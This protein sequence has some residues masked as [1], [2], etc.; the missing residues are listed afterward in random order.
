MNRQD[1]HTPALIPVD[2]WERTPTGLRSTDGQHTVDGVVV[3]SDPVGERFLIA[4]AEG[5]DP[6]G[7]RIVP[8]ELAA[9]LAVALRTARAEVESKAFDRLASDLLD[10]AR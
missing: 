8:S 2:G 9:Q 4:P 1:E 3:G 6:V 10:T 7:Y 5:G